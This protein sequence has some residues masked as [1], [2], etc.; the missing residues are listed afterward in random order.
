[1][2]DSVRFELLRGRR[3]LVVTTAALALVAAVL[4]AALVLV[5]AGVLLVGR[6]SA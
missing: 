2:L 5:G 4:L 6:R 1:M 3:Q